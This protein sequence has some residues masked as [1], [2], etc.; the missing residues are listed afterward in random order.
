MQITE[1]TQAY[2]FIIF[3]SAQTITSSNKKFSEMGVKNEP[4][5]HGGMK[6]FLNKSMNIYPEPQGS[7]KLY[8]TLYNTL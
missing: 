4:L 2:P 8:K 6:Q 7:F 3:Y 1:E 5:G